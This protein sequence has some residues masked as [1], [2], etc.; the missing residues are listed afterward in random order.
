MQGQQHI[1]YHAMYYASNVREI[2]YDV[3]EII[4]IN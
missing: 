1:K 3:W 2:K 4:G